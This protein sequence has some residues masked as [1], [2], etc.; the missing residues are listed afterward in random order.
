LAFDQRADVPS[1]RKFHLHYE[2]LVA[3]PLA[4]ITRIYAHFDM[5]LGSETLA[6]MS[7]Q[8][9]AR[10]RGG[11]GKHAPY[12]LENFKLNRPALQA[13]FAPYVQQYC[14]APR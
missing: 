4:A 10:P 1:E 12:R 8:C 2:E 6:A 5:P 11:Y 14:Q 9:E 13:A 7:R 3:A